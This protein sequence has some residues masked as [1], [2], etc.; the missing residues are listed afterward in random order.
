MANEE[1]RLLIMAP[2]RR[3]MAGWRTL[4]AIASWL[5]A[6]YYR[7]GLTLS[8]ELTARRFALRAHMLNIRSM[9][10][11]GFECDASARCAMM[12][13]TS[14]NPDIPSPSN[15]CHTLHSLHENLELWAL[16]TLRICHR[17]RSIQSPLPR[18]RA[19]RDDV[20][21]TRIASFRLH[22]IHRI[23]P[24][25]I[26]EYNETLDGNT[27]NRLSLSVEP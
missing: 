12:S 14:E 3:V 15:L 25:N 27:R 17:G 6:V 2:K 11:N 8:L 10:W 7:L 19:R 16:S 13:A 21:P 9:R 4:L 20:S 5:H 1:S 23:S 26:T 22:F 18:R 24:P